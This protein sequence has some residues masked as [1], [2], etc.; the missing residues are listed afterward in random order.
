MFWLRSGP[1]DGPIA[2]RPDVKHPEPGVPPD[3]GDARLIAPNTALWFGPP[4]T[5]KVW[6]KRIT[7]IAAA[8]DE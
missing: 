3:T 2:H 5:S 4:L 1:R 6:R 7:N 8:G